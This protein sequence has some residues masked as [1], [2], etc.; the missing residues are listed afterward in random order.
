MAATP[1]SGGV[2][3]LTWTSYNKTIERLKRTLH[4][5]SWIVSRSILT[6]LAGAT[7]PLKE[8]TLA[9]ALAI[10]LGHRGASFNHRARRLCEDLR[11]M[12]GSLVRLVKC[13][14]ETRIEFTHSS[15]RR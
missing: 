14:D 11:V 7:R 10:E 2:G 12:C 15:T 1:A 8:T 9:A 6:W 3:P 5:N 13:E 4:A